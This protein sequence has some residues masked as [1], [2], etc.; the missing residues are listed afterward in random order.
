MFET[1]ASLTTFGNRWKKKEDHGSNLRFRI[2][3]NTAPAFSFNTLLMTRCCYK[4]AN[5]NALYMTSQALRATLPHLSR[6][7]QNRMFIGVKSIY[8][9]LLP[10]QNI[11]Y[12]TKKLLNTIKL[13]IHVWNACLI[14]DIWYSINTW[15]VC[16]HLVFYQH[17]GCVCTFSI[18]STHGF[19]CVDRISNVHT[20][21]MC[22]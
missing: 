2:W 12:K 16:V 5:G 20:Q 21:P 18:L 7:E 1:H 8:K 9:G 11:K 3:W 10:K 19:P 15:V 4:C 6:T 22:W 13:H 17:M 14:N